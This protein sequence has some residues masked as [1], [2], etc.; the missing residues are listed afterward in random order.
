MNVTPA[1][2][3][4]FAQIGRYQRSELEAMHGQRGRK[5]AEYFELFPRRVRPAERIRSA[6]AARTAASKARA[7][8]L[9][10]LVDRL[11][12]TTPQARLLVEQLL[13]T[14]NLRAPLLPSEHVEFSPA[15]VP[16]MPAPRT[17]VRI[18]RELIA[19][20]IGNIVD[21]QT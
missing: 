9:D 3:S 7:D 21:R 19:L 16:V 14:R 13:D 8:N 4:Q 17:R 15:S 18:T 5:P 1:P 10:P 20:P 12:R 2:I 6:K 11:R